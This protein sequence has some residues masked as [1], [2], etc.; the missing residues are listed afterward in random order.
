M[1]ATLEIL[2]S[3]ELDD[4]VPWEKVKRNV[5]SF[6]SQKGSQVL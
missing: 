4:F 5:Q 3:P 6:S 1:E 2:S